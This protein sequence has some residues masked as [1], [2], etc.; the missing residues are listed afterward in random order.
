M[1]DQTSLVMTNASQKYRA[2]KNKKSDSRLQ[3]ILTAGALALSIE[4]F[5]RATSIG[6]SHTYEEI[7]KGRLKIK[8][9]G[10]RSL[11]LIDE[12]RRYLSELSDREPSQQA[13]VG[14]QDPMTRAPPEIS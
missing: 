8:K 1:N 2:E 10:K 6:R 14:G 12:A 13:T 5:C 3:S 9:A 7:A 11:I 4:E